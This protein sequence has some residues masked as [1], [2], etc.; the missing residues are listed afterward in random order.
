MNDT[1][2]VF[3]RIRENLKVRKNE[4]TTESIINRSLNTTLS[5]TFNT[6]MI[7]FLV[8]LIMFLFG[9]P[10]IK[11][12]LFAMLIGVVIGTYSSICIATPILIDFGKKK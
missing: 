9:G 8:V 12:F 1:V 2:I 3:D 11:G 7:L 6:S 4:E 5:R 10:A